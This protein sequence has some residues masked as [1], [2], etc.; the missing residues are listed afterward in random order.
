MEWVTTEHQAEVLAANVKLNSVAIE[1]IKD[2]DE[3][4]VKPSPCEQHRAF[5]EAVNRAAEAI[6][7]VG[8]EVRK[9]GK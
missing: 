1:I 7:R 4:C 6:E 8:R 3:C 5:I 2:C 9:L